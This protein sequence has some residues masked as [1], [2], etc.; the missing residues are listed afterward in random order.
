MKTLIATDGSSY[1]TT[2]LATAAR[3]LTRKDNRFDVVCVVPEFP[4]GSKSRKTNREGA[5]RF[6]SEYN[7]YMEQNAGRLLKRASELLLADGISAH[8][9]AKAGSPGDVLV[10]LSEDYDVVVLGSQSSAERPSPGLGPVASRIVEHVSGIA[11]VGRELLNDTTFKI[12][13]GVD[14]SARSRNA[15]EALKTSFNID[16]A[17]ITLMHVMEKPWLRLSLEQEWNAELQRAYAAESPEKAEAEALFGT[18]LRLEAEQ[19]IEDAREMLSASN[20]SIEARVEEGIPAAELLH[21][22]EIG[23]YDLAVIG[24]T[25]V[26]DLKHTMLGSVAFKLAWTA[27]CSVAVVR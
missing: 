18:E 22:V 7:D 10:S 11:L 3:L 13:V 19:I 5:K 25:G 2:A 16:G 6:R 21:E 1:A 17:Q 14:G 15:I 23:D 8:V 4:H 12:L 26:S 27:S 24:A 9:F 20:V